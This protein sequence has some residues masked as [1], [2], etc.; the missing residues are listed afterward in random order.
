MEIVPLGQ[1]E[2]DA[3]TDLARRP[4][5][6]RY[7][8]HLELDPPSVFA[9]WL[10]E[11]DANRQLSLGARRGGALIAA[12]RLSTIPRR[13]RT[14]VGV[15]A[16]LAPWGEDGDA[17]VD[18]LLGALVD[19]ADR[20][21]QIARLEL[22]APSGHP[23]V[24]GVYAARGFAVETTMRASIRRDGALAD[25]VA[26]ARIRPGTRSLEAVAGRPAPRPKAAP[27]GSLRF[28]PIHPV[29]DAEAWTAALSDESVLWGTL[30][31]PHQHPETWER[32]L[33]SN[34]PRQLVAIAAE[35]DGALAG[36][37]VLL[38]G[39][40][41]R[42]RHAA[43]LGMH[44]H[45]EHQGRGVGGRLMEE[46]LATGDRLGLERIELEVFPDNPRAVRIYEAAGF[47]LEGRRHLSCF[48]DGALID[49]LMMSRVKG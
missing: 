26:L 5:V 27:P 18:A 47:A 33:A 19:A 12:A 46:L 31:L 4:D 11:P 34:D 49:D 1:R 28:R 25:E 22:I 2:L 29:R 42:R 23:R 32:K 9:A 24:E 45:P 30:Q 39:G 16:L 13:R 36:G 41:L 3:L 10:G 48:R 37:A 21:M 15:V 35:V 40:P 38:I 14:H 17:A 8:D 43:T 44:V 20:W 7:G 6:V